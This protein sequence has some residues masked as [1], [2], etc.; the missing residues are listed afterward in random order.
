MKKTNDARKKAYETFDM[1]GVKHYLEGDFPVRTFAEVLN[2][3]ITQKA[4]KENTTIENIKIKLKKRLGKENRQNVHNWLTPGKIKQITRKSAIEI[5]FAL[6]MTCDETEIF[7]KRLFHDG[8]YLRDIKDLIYRYY[9]EKGLPYE[10]AEKKIKDYVY[11]D[12]ANPNPGR[13]NIVLDD[14]HTKHIEEE[15]E[16]IKDIDV[17]INQNEKSFGFYRRKAYE[18]FMEYYNQIKQDYDKEVEID[19]IIAEKIDIERHKDISKEQTQDKEQVLSEKL[20]EFITFGIPEIRKGKK[21]NIGKYLRDLIAEHIPTRTA[22]SGIIHQ[23]TNVDRK[24]LILA[25]LASEDEDTWI[26]PKEKDMEA[27]MEHLRIINSKLLQ[28]LGMATLDPR[29]PF[30]WI[31]MN[32]LRYAYHKNSG[33]II[34]EMDNLVKLLKKRNR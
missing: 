24:L 20:C 6:E 32:I 29:H 18:K 21:V 13:N 26:Y 34:I 33:D 2:D 22:M 28:P 5:A 16:S 1:N 15:F 17:F 4:Q 12:R 3:E 7:L 25:Y 11:L 14:E 30:D 27:F 23:H 31:I 9:L 10:D 19:H 8:F